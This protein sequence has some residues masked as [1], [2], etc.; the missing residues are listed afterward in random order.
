MEE[1]SVLSAI[2]C[3]ENELEILSENPLI[4]FSVNSQDFQLLFELP[5]DYPDA[6]PN[7]SVKTDKLSRKESENFVEQINQNCSG[8]IGSPMLMETIQFARDNFPVIKPNQLSND[9]LHSQIQEIV[10]FKLDH[11]RDVKNYTRS[12]L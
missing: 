2:F 9:E 5:I 6:I 11:M 3:A 12:L 1:V 4:I 8:M 10:F 7:L